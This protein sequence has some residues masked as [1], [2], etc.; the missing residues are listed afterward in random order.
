M[1]ARELFDRHHVSILSV[2]VVVLLLGSHKV[3][4]LLSRRNLVVSLSRVDAAI[5]SITL[6]AGKEGAVENTYTL[7]QNII[8]LGT[9]ISDWK[10]RLKD[11]E[12]RYYSQFTAMETAIQNANT[13]SSLFTS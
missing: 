7:G 8:D 5:D 6:K 3:E 12:D 1:S 10:D 11:I 13:Q 9:R 2:G 4:I